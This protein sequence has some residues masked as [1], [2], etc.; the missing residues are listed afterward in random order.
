MPVEDELLFLGAKDGGIAFYYEGTDYEWFIVVV[1]HTTKDVKY[2]DRNV[3]MHKA[4]WDYSS[5]IK[6]I[7]RNNSRIFRILTKKEAQSFINNTK[8]Y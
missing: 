5:I 4:N 7:D 2:M 6:K 8:S 3:K 1:D